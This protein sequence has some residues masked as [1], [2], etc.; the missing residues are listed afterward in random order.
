MNSSPAQGRAD[1]PDLSGESCLLINPLSCRTLYGSLASRAAELARADG[2]PV[3]LSGDPPGILALLQ[4]LRERRLPQLWVLAG[5]GTVQLIARFLLQLPADDWQPALLL[6][7]GGRANVVPRAF[8]GA[9]ALPA[10]RAALRARRERRPLA[11]ELQPLLRVE[12]PGLPPQ[13]GFVLAASSVDHGIRIC[14]DFRASGTGWW[15][16]GLF[17]DPWC[18]IKLGLK[19]AMGR[20]PLPPYPQLDVVTDN[21]ERMIASSRILMASALL[22]AGGHYNPYADRGEGPLRVTV[23]AADARRFWR[24]LPRMLS[25]RYNENMTTVQGFL[26]GRCHTM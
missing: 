12:Q 15:H 5:D 4:Q 7:G 13:H 22:H 6:L 25:G 8:G 18:L 24:H 19:I 10:L 1:L 26:S 14:R 11:V 9:P 17:A 2:V 23:V 20:S 3:V 21:G 16:R